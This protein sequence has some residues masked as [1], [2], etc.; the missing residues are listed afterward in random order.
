MNE[1]TKITSDTCAPN[2]ELQVP[3][4]SPSI[5]EIVQKYLPD[6]EWMD[7][8]KGR[9]SCPGK[10]KH[11]SRSH[12]NDCWVF[13]NGVP[14]VTCLHASCKNEVA[15]VNDKIRTVWSLYQPPVDEEVLAAAKE[16]AAKRHALEEKARASL[17]EILKRY[18]WDVT[19]I[20]GEGKYCGRISGRSTEV[21]LESMF[22]SDD[23]IWLGEPE[24]SGQ[25]EHRFNFLPRS[26]W[27]MLHMLYNGP[28]AHYTCASTFK[29]GTYSRAN[30]NV[31]STPY[32]IVEGDKV[33]GK[34]PETN[35]EK[36]ENKNACGAIF[37][38]LR[39]GLGLRLRAVVD[40]GNRS[41]HGWYDFPSASQFEE[42]KIVLPAMG[43][44]RAMFKPT[45]P[46]R[47]P[48]VRRDNGNEQRLLWIN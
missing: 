28:A 12:R 21:F 31:E 22:K 17:P 34:D 29:P 43:C 44:D 20:E 4:T 47:L 39:N 48:G 6:V 42:L 30:V 25:K 2:S 16:K 18:R 9:V 26:D 36:L 19:N 14:T 1:N 37:N 8:L 13:I 32:L 3:T 15:V 46:A 23:V 27:N 41:L 5:Q 10:H 33:L 24:D 11:T 38:W 40:S 35:D 45:Q 7:G